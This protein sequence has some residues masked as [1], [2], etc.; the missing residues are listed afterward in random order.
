MPQRADQAAVVSPSRRPNHSQAWTPASL[1]ITASATA[2]K[3][4]AWTLSVRWSPM[5]QPVSVMWMGVVSGA[6]ASAVTVRKRR[7]R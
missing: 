2:A 4:S 1:A 5:G 6:P 3:I 7:R